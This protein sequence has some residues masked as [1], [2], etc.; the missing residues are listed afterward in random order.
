MPAF[1]VTR[2]K[3]VLMHTTPMEERIRGIIA[4][5]LAAMGYALVLARLDGGAKRK[6]L[7]VIAE[8]ADGKRMTVEDCEQIS[9]Q[10]SALLDVDDP[11][12]GAYMLEVS[13][14]GMD[15]P[16][17]SAEDFKRY[18][19]RQA[20]VE[21]LL[22]V[23]GR[24]R[25]KGFIAESDSETVTVDMGADGKVELELTNIRSAKLAPTDEEYREAMKQKEEG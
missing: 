25:F 9:H 6:Q 5:P 20:K 23:G 21:T 11:I 7:V 8:R 15:R 18:Q 13:S 16:L 24:K 22:A 17:V 19:G 4:P 14:P 3:A 1:F 12:P 2:K 10:V